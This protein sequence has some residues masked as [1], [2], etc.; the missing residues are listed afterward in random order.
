MARAKARLGV[1][2]VALG[3]ALSTWYYRPRPLRAG[4][5]RQRRV[6]LPRRIE[7][8][9]LKMTE[10]NPWYG[11]KRIAVMCRR[12]DLAV[13]NRQVYRVF[14]DH[15]LFQRR[16]RSPVPE[17]HQTA[18]L[19]ELLPTGPN[20]LWQMD[21]T[22]IHVPGFGWWYAVTASALTRIDPPVLMRI[23]PPSWL[24]REAAAAAG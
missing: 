20:D 2:L 7:K 4:P 17:L 9:V 15:D 3:I 16:Q 12:A 24:G 10:D 23:D 22:Y 6:A 1:V 13:S 8:G 18:K 19:Y 5:R 11:Y 21:V 14:R